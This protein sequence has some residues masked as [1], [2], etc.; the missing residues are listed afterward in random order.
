MSL[1]TGLTIADAA[2]ASGVSAHT[3]RYYER[4]GR[5]PS[6]CTPARPAIWGCRRTSTETIR[7]AHATHPITVVQTFAFR[8]PGV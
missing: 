7:R 8:S 5:W 6:S 3:L 1:E 2:H 4:A